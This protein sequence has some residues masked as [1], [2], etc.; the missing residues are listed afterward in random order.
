MKSIDKQKRVLQQLALSA[1]L[2]LGTT[3]AAQ[4]GTLTFESGFDSPLLTQ[5][6]NVATGNFWIETYGV[7]A[8]QAEDLVG[9]IVDGSDN[10][11]CIAGGCPVNNPSNY[12]TGLNDGYLYFGLSNPHQRMQ[13][14]SLQASYVGAEGT[15]YPSTPGALVIQGFDAAG[16]TLGGSLVLWLS[17]PSNGKFNFTSFDLSPLAANAYS[18]VRIVGYG[19]NAQGNCFSGAGISNFALDNIQVAEIP[20]PAS[21][22]LFGLGLAGFAALRRRRSI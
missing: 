14:L 9:V 2:I 21:F 15:S 11:L 5:G 13:L 17:G 12:Y 6:Q 10:G 8:T 20:E 18:F 3:G 1:A 16:Q 4:A 7:G 22:A 19:C